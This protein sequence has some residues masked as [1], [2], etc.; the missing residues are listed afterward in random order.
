MRSSP[1]TAR[2]CWRWRAPWRATRR[3]GSSRQRGPYQGEI[4]ELYLDPIYQGLGLGEHLFEGCRHTL[5]MRKLN[6]LIVW[7]LLDNTAACDFYWRRGGRPD[8]QRL[9]QDR[10]RAPGEGRLRLA[11]RHRIFSEALTPPRKQTGT[12]AQIRSVP[13]AFD[14]LGKSTADSGSLGNRPCTENE[15]QK[16]PCASPDA[17]EE[18]TLTQ[19]EIRVDTVT[20]VEFYRSRQ[21]HRA[22]E[23]SDRRSTAQEQHRGRAGRVFP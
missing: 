6:G 8:R 17:A 5:D 12:C 18:V 2:W 13:C 9:H 21:S 10:R 1:A 14:G 7:A 20:A 19:S 15:C 3:I 16:L 11:L 4:Y 23:Q 22:R